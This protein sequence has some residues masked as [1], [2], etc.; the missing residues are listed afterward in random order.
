MA[1]DNLR[2]IKIYLKVIGLV[3]VFALSLFELYQCF[4]LLYFL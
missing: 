3:E 2:Q 4:T 1:A